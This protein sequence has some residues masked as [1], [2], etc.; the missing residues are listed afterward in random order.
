MAKQP[1]RDVYKRQ[2]AEVAH[3]LGILTV[4]IVTK[5]FSFEGKRKMGPVSY[6]HLKEAHRDG[7]CNAA[8]QQ[9]VVADL[10][11]LC[12]Q[13]H[14]GR[15]L[16]PLDVLG[17]A[18]AALVVDGVTGAHIGAHP[19]SYTHLDVYKRQVSDIPWNGPIGGVQVGLVDGQIVLNPTQEQ[20][21]VC[22]LYTSR[23]V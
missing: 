16:H 5:P 1:P 18:G 12:G 17:V 20:R 14:G 2:V 6:T 13:R 11:D 9:L 7:I 8:V 15:R 21:K 4:G 3:D 22:L 23:C 10:H 19:V